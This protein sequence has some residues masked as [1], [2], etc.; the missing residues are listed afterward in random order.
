MNPMS[1]RALQWLPVALLL[2]GCGGGL[3]GQAVET[4]SKNIAEKLGN[5]P[6]QLD[7]ADMAAKAR[8][9]DDVVTITSSVVF[10]PGLPSQTVQTFECKARF[11]NGNASVLSL[12]FSW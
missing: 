8:I 3:E 10:D 1:I 9:D 4:C 12:T 7:R 11:A 2:G 5:K 6:H